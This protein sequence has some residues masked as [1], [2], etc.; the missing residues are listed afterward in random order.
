[1]AKREEI[2]QQMPIFT[3]TVIQ[4][5]VHQIKQY[6]GVHNFILTAVAVVARWHTANDAL[7]TASCGTH[8]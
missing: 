4:I 1:M 2:Q 5:N 6:H 8:G 7:F 3:G